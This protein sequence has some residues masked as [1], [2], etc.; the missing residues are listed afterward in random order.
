MSNRFDG[1]YDSFNRIG[2]LDGDRM[3][4]VDFAS[5]FIHEYAPSKEK[6]NLIEAV[7][8]GSQKPTFIIS[9]GSDDP[10][11]VV[12]GKGITFDTGGLNFK[13][14][15]CINHMHL[16]KLGATF[17]LLF[18]RY[19]GTEYRNVAY[20]GGVA[21]NALSH[22]SVKPGSIIEVGEGYPDVRI[23]NTDAEGRLVLADLVKY[24]QKEYPNARR[25]ISLSTLTGLVS[26][27]F[28]ADYLTEFMLL[29]GIG[30][31]KYQGQLLDLLP[32]AAQMIRLNQVDIDS[33]YEADH[34][35]Q[36]FKSGRGSI[37]A[38]AFVNAFVKEN[39]EYFHLDIAS[40]IT[41]EYGNNLD[42]EATR[43]ISGTLDELIRL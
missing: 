41:K 34:L 12:I 32:S 18:E 5:E 10:D 13:A 8:R 36:N 4:P 39:I 24:A 30:T 3:S 38:G 28:K 25:I 9:K 35:I 11:I 21:E 22:N 16:D 27:F 17:A 42:K 14:G 23:T 20:L 19:F 29:L 37:R 1:F 15:T 2:Q 43:A 26:S 6:Y 40:L 33:L 31:H 7:G